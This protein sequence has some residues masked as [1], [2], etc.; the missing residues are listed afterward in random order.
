MLDSG[1]LE[2]YRSKATLLN[3]SYSWIVKN[4]YLLLHGTICQIVHRHY[5]Y[6]QCWSRYYLAKSSKF[7]SVW[8][9]LPSGCNNLY[10]YQ[11]CHLHVDMKNVS[12]AFTKLVNYVPFTA[13]WSTSRAY[14]HVC[15]PILVG[16]KIDFQQ[17]L[18]VCIPCRWQVH[19]FQT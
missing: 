14:S 13:S 3:G 8:D 16:F 15:I 12:T 4:C 11:I 17:F 6:T 18:A 10:F 1:F 9:E 19:S 5:R 2:L 7:P